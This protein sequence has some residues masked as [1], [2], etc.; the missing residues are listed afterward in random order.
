MFEGWCGRISLTRL[1]EVDLSAVTCDEFQV[2]V[3]SIQEMK[4]KKNSN[5]ESRLPKKKKVKSKILFQNLGLL[6][7]IN[8]SYLV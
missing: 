8:S 7:Y 6:A 5:K 3:S 1:H 2:H 4:L